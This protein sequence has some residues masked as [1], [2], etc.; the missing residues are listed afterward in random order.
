MFIRVKDRLVNLAHVAE[1]DLDHRPGRTAGPAVRI[2]MAGSMGDALDVQGDA[3]RDLHEF[4]DGST[5]EYRHLIASDAGT[6]G[7]LD[8]VAFGPVRY[9][10]AEVAAP[11]GDA[12]GAA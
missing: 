9:H 3:V 8:V 2:T 7:D 5:V 11:D 6:L 4:F 10:S 12:E 1:I